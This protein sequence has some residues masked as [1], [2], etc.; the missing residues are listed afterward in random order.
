[1]VPTVLGVMMAVVAAWGDGGEGGD[2]VVGAVVVG[3]GCAQRSSSAFTAARYAPSAVTALAL[4]P[5]AIR[6]LVAAA[7]SSSP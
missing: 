5:N 3:E 6:L 4:A 1:M 7:K 2:F